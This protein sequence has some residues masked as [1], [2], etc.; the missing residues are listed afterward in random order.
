MIA[1]VEEV[2]G[3]NILVTLLP[4]SL[5]NIQAQFMPSSI[6]SVTAGIKEEQY[7]SLG[8]GSSRVYRHA[9][10]VTSKTLRIW[11]HRGEY[12]IQQLIASSVFR[13]LY[14]G[15]SSEEAK[16]EMER[17]ISLNKQKPESLLR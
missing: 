17:N 10:L 13:L 3:L 7:I 14:S 9:G 15:E 8:L 6:H 5:V 1:A 2:S 16:S 12:T 4:F 11:H